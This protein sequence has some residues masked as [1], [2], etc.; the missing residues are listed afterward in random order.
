MLV[1]LLYDFYD[2]L[3]FTLFGVFSLEFLVSEKGQKS[4]KKLEIL[5]QP[6]LVHEVGV[7]GL[8]VM[9][10]LTCFLRDIVKSY[11]NIKDEQSEGYQ[12]CET[13]FIMLA[14]TLSTKRKYLPK[15]FSFQNGTR[16]SKLYKCDQNKRE[17][18]VGK[19]IIKLADFLRCL[20]RQLPEDPN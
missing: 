17:K 11:L 4:Q 18:Y 20:A 15:L 12:K 2:E 7:E 6:E 9:I 19:N 10:N 14:I 8:A 13:L 5:K 3:P 16:V 1:E